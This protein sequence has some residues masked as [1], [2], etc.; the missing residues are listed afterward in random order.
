M[1][2]TARAAQPKLDF[3]DPRAK[4]RSKAVR[5]LTL[6]AWGLVLLAVAIV[7]IL[8][9]TGF[10]GP[11]G[12]ILF[13]LT[14]PVIGAVGSWILALVICAAAVYLLS[15]AR[16]EIAGR[17]TRLLLIGLP[18]MLGAWECGLHL[19]RF[20]WDEQA[21]KAVGYVGLW[22][23]RLLRLLVGDSGLVV[24]IVMLAALAIVVLRI[25]PWRILAGS[26]KRIGSRRKEEAV[27]A[28]PA[29]LQ[30]L[31]PLVPVI[32]PEFE[33][34][35]PEIRNETSATEIAPEEFKGE[36]PRRPQPDFP[37]G[38]Q[39]D[40]DLSTALPKPKHYKLPSL[41]LLA[42]PAPPVM[43]DDYREFASQRIVNTLETF[44]IPCH[45]SEVITGPAVTR[46]EVVLGEGIRVNKVEGMEK[47]IAYILPAKR[48]RVEAPIPGKT[49]IGIEFPN[50]RTNLVRLK[51][52]LVTTEWQK[53]RA[54]LTMALAKDLNNRPVLADLGKMP[55][56]LVAGQT[57]SGK[58]V[59]LHSIIVSL[60][61]R[62]TPDQLRIILIDP[63][64]V[65]FGHYE[66]LPHLL[67]PVVNEISD[68]INA[69]RWS[70]QEM[71]D[72][73][74]K[75]KSKKARNILVHNHMVQPGE[76]MP[77]IVIV[78]DEM[79]DLMA[80]EGYEIEACITSLTQLARAVGIHLVLATQR[81][82]VK[83]ITG[84]I[85]ANIPA[86][87]A[88]N[89]ASYNDSRTILDY[90][91]A[92]SLLGN[93]DMLYKPIDEDTPIRAQGSYVDDEEI[94]RVV[95]FVSSQGVPEYDDEVTA[96]HAPSKP[97]KGDS[98]SGDLS[99]VD[100]GVLRDALQV[101][102]NEGEA[103]TSMLQS[104]LGLGY[105][106]ARRLMEQL[107]VKGLVGPK[108]GSKP[109][110]IRYGA[111]REALTSASGETFE[112]EMVPDNN[113]D[114]ILSDV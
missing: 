13:R 93:G 59:C 78:I 72:R 73:Y 95:E 3:L 56:L 36:K 94:K 66:G 42:P 6:E 47:D 7:Y 50:I 34:L 55:H 64:M 57:G 54:P 85:K 104:K 12:V 79:A 22:I 112:P 97:S 99:S 67:T 35:P 10:G 89:V 9:L 43:D 88:L 96:D 101:F 20:Y 77:F 110:E 32:Q 71:R 68:A 58:S 102:L 81:P 5:T 98:D 28:I 108:N 53:A 70:V 19:G 26:L 113:V 109:R 23:G 87:I 86:R 63:K 60:L 103:S 90:K 37:P 52:L 15:A 76:R 46:V 2:N 39:L 25:N 48:V 1:T 17:I 40:L 16:V 100:V 69:L 21:R 92:E 38:K 75:L 11:V 91:G 27:R 33:T 51:E 106:R 8:G 82:S 18:L 83:I 114:E 105:P 44:G 65:E 31:G 74:R 49:A 4:P 14:S 24:A 107:E 84:N 29:S 41:D 62:L 111:C 30:A 61:Y 80:Q 45:V